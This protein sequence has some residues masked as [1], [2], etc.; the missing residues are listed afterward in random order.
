MMD[1][2]HLQHAWTASGSAALNSRF[3][4]FGGLLATLKVRVVFV[5]Y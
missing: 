1:G 3:A 2:K 5:G 4:E